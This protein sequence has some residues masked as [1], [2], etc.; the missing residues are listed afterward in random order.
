MVIAV[1]L[2]ACSVL[3]VL[4]WLDLRDRRL[5]AHWVGLVAGFYLMQALLLQA[6]AATIGAHVLTGCAAFAITAVMFRLGWMGGGDVKLAGAVFL[7]AGPQAG[8]AVLCVVSLAGLPLALLMVALE[9]FASP[10]H[11]VKHRW[12]AAFAVAR[13]VPYGVALACGGA[14]A[15]WMPL[16]SPLSL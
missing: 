11:Q 15:V 16:T 9:R 10:T 2:F 8:V 12:L 7:W 6:P 14:W 5:P 4:A 3:V 13:G 1:K